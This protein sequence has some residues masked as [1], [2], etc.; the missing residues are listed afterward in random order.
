MNRLFSKSGNERNEI[1]DHDIKLRL[2]L[3]KSSNDITHVLVYKKYQYY[4]FHIEG[5]P[6]IIGIKLNDE[7]FS[8]LVN[9]LKITDDKIKHKD[10]HQEVKQNRCIML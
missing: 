4:S 9:A 8:E 3:S 6:P 2:I 1:E 10:Q 5:N 7:Q